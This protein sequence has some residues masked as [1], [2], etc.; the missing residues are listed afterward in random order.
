ME[1]F[2]IIAPDGWTEFDY[3]KLVND[4]LINP[5][6]KDIVNNSQM[7]TDALTTSGVLVNG[8]FVNEA[9]IIDDKYMWLKLG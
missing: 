9:K 5:E 4:G 8:E 3:E 7:V 1:E 2:M 6:I